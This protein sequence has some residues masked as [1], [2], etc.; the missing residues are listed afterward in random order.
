VQPLEVLEAAFDAPSVGGFEEVGDVGA[1]EERFFALLGVG[2]D[3]HS[4]VLLLVVDQAVQLRERSLLDQLV[5]HLG[6]G[7]KRVA[8]PELSAL[9]Q[10][11]L[12]QPGQ[13]FTL[14]FLQQAGFTLLPLPVG[15]RLSLLFIYLFLLFGDA[16]EALHDVN[17]FLHGVG[18]EIDA[19]AFLDVFLEDFRVVVCLQDLSEQ[20]ILLFL[21]LHINR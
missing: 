8:L 7:I 17:E 14:L 12:L 6:G 16:L 20:V 15:L 21:Q 19:L 18:V 9:L 4:N 11:R 13:V 3:L 10:H 5:E 1:A 2:S